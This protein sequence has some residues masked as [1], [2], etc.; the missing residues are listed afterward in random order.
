MKIT[1]HGKAHLEGTNK[2]G[3]PYNCNAVHYL[4]PA[5]GVEGLA[6][7]TLYLDPVN[8][9]IGNIIVGREYELQFDDRRYPVV[10]ELIQK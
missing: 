4:A 6:A 10:F 9:P 5:R 3:Q 7:K 8:F 1:I 2:N